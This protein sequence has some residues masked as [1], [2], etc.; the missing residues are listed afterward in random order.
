MKENR[1]K[2]KTTNIRVAT[3]NETEFNIL[4]ELE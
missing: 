2:P 3:K 1:T 4:G